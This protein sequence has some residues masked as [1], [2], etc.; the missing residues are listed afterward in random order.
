ML[1]RNGA[2]RFRKQVS[3]RIDGRMG[4]NG[5]DRGPCESDNKGVKSTKWLTSLFHGLVFCSIS[6]PP[7]VGVAVRLECKWMRSLVP[8]LLGELWL[9]PHDRQT[10]IPRQSIHQNSLI[11]LGLSVPRYSKSRL[12][13]GF[14][15]ECYPGALE[16]IP[17]LDSCCKRK[18]AWICSKGRRCASTMLVTL[19][20]RE[21]RKHGTGFRGQMS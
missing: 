20:I 18:Q 1:G 13:L 15:V 14:E 4:G 2:S 10:E 16:E 8:T 7:A 19:P 5:M 11:G 3:R 17:D 21:R 9:G 6:G 12:C